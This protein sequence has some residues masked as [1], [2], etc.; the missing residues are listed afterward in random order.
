MGDFSGSWRP[1]HRVDSSVGTISLEGRT[2]FLKLTWT[3]L[4]C[5]RAFSAPTY[6]PTGGALLLT[7][8]AARHPFM[9]YSGEHRGEG[10]MGTG[11]PPLPLRTVL[12]FEARLQTTPS[13]PSPDFS[14]H[15]SFSEHLQHQQPGSQNLTIHWP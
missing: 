9:A 8:P 2:I 11:G 5:S 14:S 1:G 15:C 13:M 4:L 10:A 12:G 7:A 3:Q 6:P